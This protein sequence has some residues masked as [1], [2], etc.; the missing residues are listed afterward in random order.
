MAG[1]FTSGSVRRDGGAAV[2]PRLSSALKNELPEVKGFSER[3]IKRMLAFYR[4]YPE[5]GGGGIVPRAV[6]QTAGGVIC[7]LPAHLKSVLPA[8]GGVRP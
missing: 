7:A 2:I 1:S 5:L 6:A 4:E 8:V 3:N